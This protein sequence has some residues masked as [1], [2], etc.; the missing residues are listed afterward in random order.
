MARLKE[1][2]VE[3]YEQ[4][5]EFCLRDAFRTLPIAHWIKEHVD[6]SPFVR[7]GWLLGEFSQSREIVGL[8]LLSETGILYPAIH[9]DESVEQ[10]KNIGKV[11]PNMF[12]VVLG[13]EDFVDH[14][15]KRLQSIGMSARIDQHQLF[16]V[17]N[18]NLFCPYSPVLDLE[19]AQ[20]RH[21]DILVEASAAMA[22]EESGDNARQR[23]PGL[24]RDRIATRLL[25]QRDF[26][27]QENNELIYKASVSSL[28]PDVGQIE[29]VYTADQ[30]RR[31]GFGGRGTSYVIDWVLQRCGSAALLVNRENLGARRMYQ[32]LGFQTMYLSRTIFLN[33]L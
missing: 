15:W 27:F 5:L 7:K 21:L 24:F 10:L 1:L 11:N 31:Q 14:L 13:P 9:S 6:K 16:Y 32:M 28:T 29:G 4:A 30:Y 26:I 12:R 25:R 20:L 17:T 3:H 33:T 18:K 22:K 8:A 19:I 23:N 2:G